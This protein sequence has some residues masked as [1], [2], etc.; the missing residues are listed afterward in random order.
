MSA[1]AVCLAGDIKSVGRLNHLGEYVRRGAQQGAVEVE[2]FGGGPAGRNLVV[3]R[4]FAA[5]GHGAEQ[6]RSKFLLNGTAAT[7]KDVQAKMRDLHIQ[8]N[9]LCVF[10]AQFR[11]GEFAEMNP[12]EASAQGH[13]TESNKRC[14]HATAVTFL[15]THFASLWLLLV[16]FH[17]SLADVARNGEGS[18]R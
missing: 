4:S 5:E 6:E 3:Y 2:L 17:F 9:N 15:P 13:E 12:T 16:S 7:K 8:V 14:E 11:V 18:Q 1:I 10:L